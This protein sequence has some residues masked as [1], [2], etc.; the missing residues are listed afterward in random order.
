MFHAEIGWR[1]ESPLS[2]DMLPVGLPN[3]KDMDRSWDIGCYPLFCKLQPTTPAKPSH[4]QATSFGPTQEYTT[5]LAG[6]TDFMSTLAPQG[7]FR[8]IVGR[9]VYYGSA[10]RLPIGSARS[11]QNQ[12][13]RRGPG[14]GREGLGSSCRDQT[15]A[16][17]SISILGRLVRMDR[18][19]PTA[20][21]AAISWLCHTNP[22]RHG[23]PRVPILGLNTSP[24]HQHRTYHR[25][26]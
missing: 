25:R 7:A 8:R 10:P 23:C 9:G 17:W 21:V 20:C 18:C 16:L 1:S 26:Y 4:F 6:T 11:F 12:C 15:T 3:S 14:F 19:L 5:T 2:E 13:G 24:Q 22:V